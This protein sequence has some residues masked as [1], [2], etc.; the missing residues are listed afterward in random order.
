MQEDFDRANKDKAGDNK[1]PGQGN[2]VRA[3]AR[4]KRNSSHIE[5]ETENGNDRNREDED[6]PWRKAALHGSAPPKLGQH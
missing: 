1:G 6:N 3:D 2:C 4:S 5:P